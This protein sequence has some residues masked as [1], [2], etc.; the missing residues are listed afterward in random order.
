MEILALIHLNPASAPAASAASSSSAAAPNLSRLASTPL[1]SLSL[2]AP[3]SE[4]APLP[5]KCTLIIAPTSLVGQWF[6]EISSRSAAHSRL[7]V[8]CWY[9]NRTSALERIMDYD[10][11][12]TTFGIIH[13]EQAKTTKSAGGYVSPLQ[14]I[15]WHRI[16]VDESHQLKGKN[17]RQ[18]QSVV[19]LHSQR[20]WLLSGTPLNTQID[21]LFH[22]FAFF[23]MPV[24]HSSQLLS[25]VRRHCF[26]KSGESGSLDD[27]SPR[28]CFGLLERMLTRTIM[29][30]RKDQ[31][32]NGRSSLI[33]LPP[34]T[35]DVIKVHFTPTER[36]AY[37]KMFEFARLRF[38]E[39]AA[40][41]SVVAQT[42]CIMSLLSPLRQ[43]CSAGKQDLN[44]IIEKLRAVAA[45]VEESATASAAASAAAKLV[46]SQLDEAQHA[47]NDDGEC[48]ICLDVMEDAL[49]TL[50][51]HAFCRGQSK[52][53]DKTSDV[54]GH[55]GMRWRRTA[56]FCA[57]QLALLLSSFGCGCRAHR[58][59]QL[60]RVLVRVLPLC[61]LHLQSLPGPRAV[62]VSAVPV[63]RAPEGFG[64][65]QA[66]ASSSCGAARR[67]VEGGRGGQVER[68]LQC[69][70]RS[71][72]RRRPS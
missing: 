21:D 10:V 56:G 38:D 44:A 53:G 7:K 55:R 62:R 37:N 65:A 19:L 20:R 72:G 67:G 46:Q 32:F 58:F 3:P 28:E 68:L 66:A 24:L 4:P 59:L 70:R 64:C 41:G 48:S 43:A 71:R 9:G 69:S 18:S 27:F 2:S 45:A 1:P 57:G 51:K 54:G 33:E 25:A 8:L 29:R 16:V 61:R 5:S 15:E 14:R 30:H 50:C 34:R 11:V 22:Q 6:N 60:A 42:F 31:S 49:M 39:L 17:T 36:A 23:R 47:F 63:A 40:R 13:A 52:A 26:A 35:S 12:L